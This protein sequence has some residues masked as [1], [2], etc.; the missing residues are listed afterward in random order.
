MVVV[1]TVVV[2]VVVMV[3]AVVAVVVPAVVP[4]AVGLFGSAA[5][6][7]LFRSATTSKASAADCAVFTNQLSIRTILDFRRP[8]DG[9]HHK[10]LLDEPYPE[11]GASPEGRSRI[12]VE[13]INKPV[14]K[15]CATQYFVL[16]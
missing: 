4:V 10:N 8:I 2:A 11:A 12:R 6:R 15:R 1:V 3:A 13:F 16:R 14:K 9:K 5:R 7:L